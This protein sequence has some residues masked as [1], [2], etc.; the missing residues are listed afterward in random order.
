V[1]S[2]LNKNNEQKKTTAGGDIEIKKK[3]NLAHYCWECKLIHPLWR[4]VWVSPEKNYFLI[5]H[6]IQLS[7]FWVIHSKEIS[8]PKRY[9]N[10][11]VF[12]VI[13][14]IAKI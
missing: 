7:H 13:F 14:T 9:L 5:Y 2:C 11:R 12:V 8:I 3:R 1:R 6:M 10:A 4:T